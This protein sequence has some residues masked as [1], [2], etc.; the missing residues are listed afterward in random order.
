M[1]QENKNSEF[2]K[3]S[4]FFLLPTGNEILDQQ[5]RAGLLLN[6]I[7]AEKGYGIHAIII[8]GIQLEGKAHLGDAC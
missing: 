2:L 4:E 3:N 5:M 7:S 6:V 1:V 8:V